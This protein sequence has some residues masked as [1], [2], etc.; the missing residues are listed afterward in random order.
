[1]ADQKSVNS[2][3]PSSESNKKRG[4]FSKTKFYLFEYALFQSAVFWIGI[5]FSVACYSVFNL[6]A[7]DPVS[8]SIV[9]NLAWVFGLM[10]V[11]VPAAVIS[12]ARVTAEERFAPSRLDQVLRKV[13]FYTMLTIAIFSATIFTITT[14]YSVSRALFGLEESKSLLAVSAPSFVVVLFHTYFIAFML[15]GTV[16]SARLRR[17]NIIVTSTVGVILSILIL[18]IASINGDGVAK[19][20]RTVKDLKEASEAIRQDYRI[21]GAL[22][23]SIDDLADL[24]KGI[25]ARF[26]DKTYTY[27]V[28]SQPIYDQPVMLEDD[29]G[30]SSSPS[31]PNADIAIGI[32][33]NYY[34]LC[35]TFKNADEGYYGSSYGAY[36][37][38]YRVDSELDYHPKGYHCYNLYAY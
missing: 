35:A 3:R 7:G 5:S 22:T 23:D 9:E 27:K 15:R 11:F 38:S 2:V 37:T 30:S 8:T 32:N 12:Y 13:I 33:Q 29:M 19:D 17:I 18:G 24:D 25:K 26:Y 28:V 20:K 21:N 6:I 34:Q 36:D 14:V 16:T 31:E 4:I 1:M 10:L